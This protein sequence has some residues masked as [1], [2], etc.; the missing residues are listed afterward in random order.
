MRTLGAL[1]VL[2]LLAGCVAL[3]PVMSAAGGWYTHNRVDRLEDD[4]IEALEKR[5]S[6]L[7][8]KE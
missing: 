6:G 8:E 2:G 1:L 4:R 3:P 5:V 7:E